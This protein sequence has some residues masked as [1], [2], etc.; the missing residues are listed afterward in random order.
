MGITRGRPTTSEETVVRERA[1]RLRRELNDFLGVRGRTLRGFAQELGYHHSKLCR[2][3][4]GEWSPKAS[5][6]ASLRF[7][8]RLEEKLLSRDV[9]TDE[10]ALASPWEDPGE[11]E[12]ADDRWYANHLARL[13]ELHARVGGAAGINLLSEFYA[14]AV[15]GPAAYRYRM[16]CNVLSVYGA[17]LLSVLDESAARCISSTCL[18]RSIRRIAKLERTA[19]GSMEDADV[20]EL[21]AERILSAAGLGLASGGL[22]LLEQG[23]QSGP[24]GP[25][26]EGLMRLYEAALAPHPWELGW[27]DN[28][29]YLVDVAAGLGHDP[30]SQWRER[31]TR[32]VQAGDRDTVRCVLDRRPLDHLREYWAAGSRCLLE[33]GWKGTGT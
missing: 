7:L 30:E 3:R 26:A 14:Q 17:L 21:G 16:C 1:E 4:S 13:K 29:L 2:F 27:M 8:E 32:V 10:H 18:D 24:R 33:G 9:L 19:L 31:A 25:H 23:A 15:H 22:L 28:F 12:R 11:G 20:G 6:E 5:S